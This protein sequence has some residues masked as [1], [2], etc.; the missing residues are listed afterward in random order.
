AGQAQAGETVVLAPG[1]ASF[2]E[3]RDFEERGAAFRS[4]VEGL[5]A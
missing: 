1:C 3:F 5:G 4:L 2:D